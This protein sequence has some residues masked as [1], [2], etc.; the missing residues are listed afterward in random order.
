VRSTDHQAA[1]AVYTASVGTYGDGGLRGVC[2]TSSAAAACARRTID[3]LVAEA[4]AYEVRSGRPDLWL[5]KR[6]LP[7]GLWWEITRW[8]VDGEPRVVATSDDPGETGLPEG[9]R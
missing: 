1:P 4:H 7:H 5:D 3:E 8:V 9:D 2:S 6:G